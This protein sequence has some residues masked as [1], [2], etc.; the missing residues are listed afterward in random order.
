MWKKEAAII[1][2]QSN[3]LYVIE[4]TEKKEKPNEQ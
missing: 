3:L 2:T 4:L 1:N